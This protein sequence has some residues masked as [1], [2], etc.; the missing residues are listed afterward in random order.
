MHVHEKPITVYIRDGKPKRKWFV[1][2]GYKY[3]KACKKVFV[4]GDVV[5]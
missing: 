4:F 3:C 2:N 1:L 5:E